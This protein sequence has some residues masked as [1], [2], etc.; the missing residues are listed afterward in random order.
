MATHSNMSSLDPE[1]KQWTSYAERLDFYFEANN[2]TSA[3]N[4]RAILN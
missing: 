3:E 4:K 2:V 1:K